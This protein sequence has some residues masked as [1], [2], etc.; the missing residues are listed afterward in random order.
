MFSSYLLNSWGEWG[1]SLW[2][3]QEGEGGF[4]GKACPWRWDRAQ[5]AG[6]TSYCPPFRFWQIT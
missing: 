5:V 4:S 1:L 6:L 2:S 3:L